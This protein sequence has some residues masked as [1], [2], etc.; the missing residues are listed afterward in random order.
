MAT[1][2][3]SFSRALHVHAVRL[4]RGSP[5]HLPVRGANSRVPCAA[6]IGNSSRLQRQPLDASSLASF[7]VLDSSTA[8]TSLKATCRRLELTASARGDGNGIPSCTSVTKRSRRR[9]GQ[10]LSRTALRVWPSHGHETLTAFQSLL[11]WRRGC[12]TQRLGHLFSVI[13]QRLVF[14]SLRHSPAAS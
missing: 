10:T 1:S 6:P 13:C 5:I 9:G 8:A 3:N 7:S 12:G 4:L 11:W 14:L 2:Q